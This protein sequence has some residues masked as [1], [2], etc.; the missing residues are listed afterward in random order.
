V[1]STGRPNKWGLF[2]VR[3]NVWEWSLD[4]P[5]YRG[6]SFASTG[7]GVFGGLR[8]DAKRSANSKDAKDSTGGFRIVLVPGN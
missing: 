1:G 6:G 8:L 7:E 3:G 4:G 5:I 2:D